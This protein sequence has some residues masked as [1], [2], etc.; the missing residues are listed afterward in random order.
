MV[1]KSAHLKES[2]IQRENQ[3]C[4]NEERVAINKEKENNRRIFMNRNFLYIFLND[5]VR[6]EILLDKSNREKIESHEKISGSSRSK[7]ILHDLAMSR[8]TF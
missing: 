2:S 6:E 5:Q 7:R 8:E 1:C 3:M 4:E